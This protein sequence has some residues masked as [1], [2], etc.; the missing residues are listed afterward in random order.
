LDEIKNAYFGLADELAQ[1]TDSIPDDIILLL[2]TVYDNEN[3]FIG[4]SDA[5]LIYDK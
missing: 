5:A 1:E 4:I 3:Y 2:F